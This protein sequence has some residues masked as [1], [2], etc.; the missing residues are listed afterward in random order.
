V[1]LNVCYQQ[2]RQWE[3][4]MVDPYPLSSA[5]IAN[6]SIAEKAVPCT[7]RVL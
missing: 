4:F 3:H 1:T 2:A 6:A 7:H 5:V